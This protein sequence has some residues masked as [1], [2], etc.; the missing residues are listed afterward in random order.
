VE[1][2]VIGVP[3][4]NE[5]ATIAQLAAALELGSAQLGEVTRCE[6]VLA[7][8]AGGDD[9]L[10]RWQS[11]PFRIPHRVLH[12]PDGLTGKGRNVKLLIR[13]ALDAGAHLLLVD[14]DLRAFQPSNVGLF[15]RAEQLDRA[16]LILPL[17][18]RPLGE[19]NSTDF[20]ACPLLYAASGARI[21]QPLAGQMLLSRRLLET[22]DVDTLPDDYG[23]D[24]A[25]TMHAL[26]GGLPVTQV[27][28]AFPEHD[29]GG[30]SH[31]IMREVAIAALGRLA[32]GLLPHRP[33]VTWPER[34]W[35]QFEVPPRSSR[36]L[37][38]LIEPLVPADQMHRWRDLFGAPPEVP[39]D[40][41][42]DRLAAAVHR[43]RAGEPV[44]DLAAGLM[45]PFLVHA[46]Y[47]RRLEVDL[48]GAET[49][50]AGLGDRL[51]AALS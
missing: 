40:L 51:A 35:E 11:H 6:L 29:G 15:V 14:A 9:T 37:E 39:R 48:A 38:A 49:Y 34:Y 10:P 17:W 7:Y 47:R 19:G 25:I 16:G 33:D 26:D 36:S 27:V 43:A 5:A 46:E 8:Q 24:V 20:L 50:L 32:T 22:I 23:I 18:C 45:Y 21:R 31:Q 30:N 1:E 3:A 2:L 28:A 12:C 13:H 42:C 4:C 41:W 44:P